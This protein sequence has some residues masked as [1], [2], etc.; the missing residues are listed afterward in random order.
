MEQ[1]NTGRRFI[2][3]RRSFVQGA[4]AGVAGATVLGGTG[5]LPAGVASEA[6][7]AEPA[8]GPGPVAIRLQINGRV[9]PV[10][11][12]P[13]TTLAHVLRGIGHRPLP[14][15]EA[16]TGAKIACDRGTCGACTVLVDG[17]AVYSCMMLAIDAQGHEIT[18]V[19]GLARGDRLT[20]VQEEMVNKD[21][22]QCGFC[23]PGFVVSMTALLN[24]NPS[25][26]VREVQEGLSGNTCRC[27]AYPRIFEAALAASRK[28]GA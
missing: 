16:L 17:K 15:E 13:R 23:T 8:V 24:E 10:E 4:S 22:Y 1:E 21:G 11:V 7:A 19:E 9:R 28:K 26:T 3:S 2:V 25:P 12:E 5:V 20:P 14:P 18:T 27:G 6:A